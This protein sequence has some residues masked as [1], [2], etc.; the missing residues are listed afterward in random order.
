[1]TSKYI[2]NNY[3]SNISAKYSALMGDVSA[4][5]NFDLG[6]EFELVICEVLKKVLPKKYGVCRG[7]LVSKDGEVKGDDIIIYDRSR[8]PQIRLFDESDLAHKQE[9][10]IEAAYAYIE[11]K[12]SLIN[13]IDSKGKGNSFKKALRQVS[14][15]KELVSKR[16]TIH[17]KNAF[18]PYISMDVV[19]YS[20][21]ENWPKEINPFFTAIMAPRVKTT[22]GCDVVVAKDIG[23]ELKG[24]YDDKY[25]PDLIVAGNDVCF[26][27]T[28]EGTYHSPFCIEDSSSLSHYNVDKHAFSVGMCS[29]IYALDTICLGIMPWPSIIEDALNKEKR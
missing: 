1:M 10:P 7:F 25:S 22:R 28:V 2:Y 17:V 29:L 23:N 19:P 12:N 14:E 20:G 13:G 21:R 24:V 8:F 16:E 5:F 4:N 27:P 26:L 3:L 18:N 11:A 15:V 6:T 9:I